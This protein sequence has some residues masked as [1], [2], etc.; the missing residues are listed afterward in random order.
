MGGDVAGAVLHGVSPANHGSDTPGGP[1]A[2]TRGHRPANTRPCVTRLNPPALS[3]NA[4]GAHRRMTVSPRT[5]RTFPRSRRCR[6]C[7]NVVRFRGRVER[8]GS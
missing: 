8:V 7:Y 1:D 4:D 6:D 2:A 5:R 3:S